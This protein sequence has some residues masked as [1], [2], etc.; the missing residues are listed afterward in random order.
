MMGRLQE[1]L[2]GAPNR[3]SD[4]APRRRPSWVLALGN[5]VSDVRFWTSRLLCLAGFHRWEKLATTS[6]LAPPVPSENRLGVAMEYR[7]CKGRPACTHITDASSFASAADEYH[8][9]P[10]ASGPLARKRIDEIARGPRRPLPV[11]ALPIEE[12]EEPS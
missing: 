5:R 6:W 12:R 8:G 10:S 11:A 7:R 9:F 3:E 1:W 4:W 2:H